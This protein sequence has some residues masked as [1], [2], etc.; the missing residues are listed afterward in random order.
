M[1]LQQG[2][3]ETAGHAGGAF[4]VNDEKPFRLTDRGRQEKTPAGRRAS[5]G[6]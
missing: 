6:D 3:I 5:T 1:V 2:A 4:S